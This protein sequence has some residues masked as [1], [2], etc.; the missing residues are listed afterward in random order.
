MEYYRLALDE[1]YEYVRVDAASQRAEYF[2]DA[3]G[4][5]HDDPDLA[6]EI[7]DG[8]GEEV[9]IAELMKALI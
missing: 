6:A 2:D 9:T 1:G 5:W 4:T 8:H 7:L 3:S